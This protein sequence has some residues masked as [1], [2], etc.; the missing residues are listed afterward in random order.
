[1]RD[2]VTVSEVFGSN[3][4]AITTEH[5]T[6]LSTDEES[7]E[8]SYDNVDEGESCCSALSDKSG[9]SIPNVSGITLKDVENIDE[10]VSLNDESNSHSTTSDSS[11]RGSKVLPYSTTIRQD[12]YNSIVLHSITAAMPQYEHKS[13]EELRLEDYLT[14]TVVSYSS[15]TRQDGKLSIVLQS[16]T[17]MPQYEHK[18]LEELRLE[19]L[20]GNKG[21]KRQA[22]NNN[23]AADEESNT[24]PDD[25]VEYY[26]SSSDKDDEDTLQSSSDD[27]DAISLTDSLLLY[28][29][30]HCIF[31]TKSIDNSSGIL[32]HVDSFELYPSERCPFRKRSAST[33]DDEDTDTLSS[34]SSIDDLSTSNE[35]RFSTQ[36]KRTQIARIDK[37][38]QISFTDHLDERLWER[39]FSKNDFYRTVLLGNKWRNN[40]G[41]GFTHNAVT[42]ITDSDVEVG[43]TIYE[44]NCAE[45]GVGLRDLKVCKGIYC[46]S[47]CW[48][49][50]VCMGIQC[51]EC[52]VR[53]KDICERGFCHDCCWGCDECAG[54][55]CPGCKARGNAICHRGFCHDCCW[56]CDICYDD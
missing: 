18:S 48:G 15:T 19:D 53:G 24:I 31:R 32:H 1:M 4:Y 34:C 46:L 39:G 37:V 28:P 26:T 33:E 41:W 52:K 56:G 38:L 49:C 43:I 14:G 27:D 13:F 55:E 20:A 7:S 42:A 47:C 45:C 21:T 6:T 44:H 2:D 51:P 35:S 3:K 22:I 50:D 11:N 8:P 29:P 5:N 9:L 16:I 12:G 36:S 54:E 17:V 10:Q 30:E 40:G 25:S 23:T